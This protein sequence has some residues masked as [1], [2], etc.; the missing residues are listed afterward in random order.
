M[1]R[2]SSV[3]GAAKRRLRRPRV[4]AFAALGA[5]VGAYYVWYPELPNLPFW[6]DVGLLVFP[7]IPTVL[8]LALIALPLRRVH[9]GW[10]LLGA[11]LLAVTAVVCDIADYGVAS[12]FAKL[13]A[14]I[15]LGWWFLG[16][17]E[18]LNW[19]ILVASLIPWVDA[20]SVWRGPTHHIVTKRKGIFTHLSFAFPVPHAG[21][22]R[23]G[24]PDLL[25]F[26]LF[27]AAA[28]RFRLHVWRTFALT[29]LSFGATVVIANA[30]LLWQHRRRSSVPAA[31]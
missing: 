26:A 5:A 22:A 29:T 18:S 25:F 16:Y 28:D 3:L 13:F 19:V 7:I 27:L 14:P 31:D 9:G 10:V 6:W 1:G 24:L 8:A 11:A 20:Y 21:A 23:L 12:N 4:V 30:D 2:A 15:L 17:F